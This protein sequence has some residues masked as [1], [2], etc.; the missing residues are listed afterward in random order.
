MSSKQHKKKLAAA[1]KKM[2][3]S[4]ATHKQSTFRPS[5]AGSRT[6][7]EFMARRGAEKFGLRPPPATSNAKH[8]EIH[9]DTAQVTK[10]PVRAKAR[11]A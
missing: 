8:Y 5:G 2:G 9:A 10:L 3:T 6:L 1:L 11:S 7:E 4:L